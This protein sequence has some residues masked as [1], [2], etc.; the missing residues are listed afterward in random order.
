MHP[1]EQHENIR[2]SYS[3][4]FLEMAFRTDRQE[5]VH[6]ADGR[7]K[8][9]TTC[10][11]S[12]EFF[13]TIK[14]DTIETLSY[15]HEGC[16]NTNACANAVIDLIEKK[17]VADAW[18][19][20]PQAISTYLESLPENHF[21]CAELAIDALKQALSDARDKQKSPWKKLYQ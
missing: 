1:H 12:I 21:H 7:G 5:S 16:M 15:A 14:D 18:A 9:A 8:K 4:K 2:E 3:L 13:L 20:S 10:G 11:D 6:H 19:L 17:H